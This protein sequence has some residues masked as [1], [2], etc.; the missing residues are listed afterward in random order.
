M[1]DVMY[2]VCAVGTLLGV[3]QKIPSLRKEPMLSGFLT[4]KAQSILPHTGN[5]CYEWLPGVQ[6]KHSVLPVQD[7]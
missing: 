4:L 3:D 2:S 5:R 7:I 1:E 6:L